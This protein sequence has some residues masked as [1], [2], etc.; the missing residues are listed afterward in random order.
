[1][2]NSYIPYVVDDTF[3]ISEVKN[4]SNE[5]RRQQGKGKNKREETSWNDLRKRDGI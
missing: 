1:M 4:I 2:E 3:Q 5:E